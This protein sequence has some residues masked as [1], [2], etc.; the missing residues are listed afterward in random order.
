MR[1][2]FVM[3]FL[4][5]ALLGSCSDRS[6][7]ANSASAASAIYHGGDIITLE[8]D[9]AAYAEAV[10]VRDGKIVFVG[11]K[12]EA[13]KLKGDS[14]VIHDL[15]GKTLIP[16]FIDGHTHFAGLG[17]QAVT[18]NL[19][20]TPDGVCNSIP[21]LQ[22]ILTE[23]HQKNG[24]DKTGGWILGHGFD[25]AVL[26]EERFPTR[27]DLDQVSKEIPICIVH[28]SGHFCVLNSKGLELS[29]VT[30]SSKD[31]SGGVIRRMPNSKEPNG[32]LE[33]NAAFPVLLPL[34]SPSDPA[35]VDYYF[36]K[37][38]DL[39]AS[40]GYTTVNEGMAV[41]NH[42]QLADYATRGKLKMDLVSYVNYAF[43]KFLHSEWN[44][45]TY[46]NHYRIGGVKVTLDGSP[47]G[48]TA[49]R[50]MPYLIPPDG[51]KAGYKGY[52]AIPDDAAVQRILDSAFVNNWQMKAHCN[53]D[54]AIDQWLRAIRNA[55][56]KFGNNNRRNILIHGQL[57]RMDQLDSL[58]KYDIVGSFFPMHTFYWG[59]W[60]KKIIGPERAAQISP[61]KSAIRKGIHVTS[62]TDAPVA[63]PNMIM[64]LWTSVNRVSRSGTVMGADERL[65]PYEALQATT[66]GGAYQFFEEASKG[67]LKAGKL[68]D[69]VVLDKNP[70]KVDPMTIKDIRVMETIKEGHTIFHR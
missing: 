58:K 26:K 42:E 19:L 5:L 35:L 49:W 43:P 3:Y 20:A 36:D 18:A 61:I 69:L 62:H 22:K 59:D 45:K 53:G 38:Q 50:T 65:T 48:R 11:D 44:S 70:L 67:S 34:Y 66:I 57:I 7:P 55:A 23:W 68:A 47:Q 21:D 60:Y 4:V 33:E 54:A 6:A 24:T 13:M 1:T 25:D 63:F 32:V 46:K 14:T 56:D 39:A 12:S 8:G 31:P 28:I 30:S 52:A 10:A 64:I 15:Q 27:E 16:G 51:Q 41:K 40:F 9:S 2:K 29:K 37:G 17:A